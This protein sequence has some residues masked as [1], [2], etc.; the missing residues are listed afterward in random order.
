MFQ[1][2]DYLTQQRLHH[3]DPVQNLRFF[4]DRT[5]CRQHG[6]YS[7]SPLDRNEIRDVSSAQFRAVDLR[8]EPFIPFLDNLHF[9]G[10]SHF[11][12]YVVIIQIIANSYWTLLFIDDRVSP[13]RVLD[14]FHRPGSFI[15][16]RNHQTAK[17]TGFEDLPGQA[18]QNLTYV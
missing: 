18:R 12:R 7:I 1:S 4:L 5:A 13:K 14:H 6:Q 16:P 10:A 3:L 15:Y 8:I 17:D 9:P 11:S 2:N